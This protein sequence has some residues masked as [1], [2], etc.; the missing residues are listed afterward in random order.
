MDPLPG[1]KGP[2]AYNYEPVFSEQELRRMRDAAAPAE[3][4]DGDG[5]DSG[6]DRPAPPD[7]PDRMN[8][9]DWCTCGNCEPLDSPTQCVCCHEVGNCEQFLDND[10]VNCVSDHEDFQPVCMHRAVLRTALVARLDCRGHARRRLPQILENVLVFC[11]FIFLPLVT[12]TTT[13]TSTYHVSAISHRGGG[14]GQSL[15][16]QS[17]QCMHQQRFIPSSSTCHLII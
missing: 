2:E 7:P 10:E 15:T 14:G 13:S 4:S 11:I 1:P 17:T 12:S 6:D 5:T 9:R 8:T 3:E 16:E